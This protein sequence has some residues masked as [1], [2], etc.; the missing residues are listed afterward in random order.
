MEL[1][2]LP[3]IQY[4]RFVIWEIDP[5]VCQQCGQL[6]QAHPGP[7]VSDAELAHL[8]TATEPRGSQAGDGGA[9]ED[10]EGKA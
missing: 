2:D 1:N 7:S 3:R 10:G 5:N 6:P 4:H 8:A 9:V